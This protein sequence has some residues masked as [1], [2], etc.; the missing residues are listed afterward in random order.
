MIVQEDRNLILGAQ[1]VL[2]E[3]QAP[4][5]AAEEAEEF[6][7]H[8]LGRFVLVGPREES[9]RWIYRAVVHDLELS[10]TCRP[11]DVRRCLASILE[12]A[13]RRGIGVLGAE[14]LGLW[15]RSGLG[16]EEVVGAFDDAIFEVLGNLREPMRLT[17][18]LR[19]LDTI[20]TASRL[21][22]SSLLRRA[23]RS[24]HE[25]AGD[26]A[27]VEVRSKGQRF[28]CRFVPGAISGYQVTRS[29]HGE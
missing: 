12:D 28:Q 2:E 17:L 25:V 10:P 8:L 1:T 9:P 6:D 26:A 18:L 24:F 19:D 20:E 14:P 22:R 11:G 4:A 5:A 7:S 3:E 21:L 16:L 29:G 23:S 15:R 27:V 13:A